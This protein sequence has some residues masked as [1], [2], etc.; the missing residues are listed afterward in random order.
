MCAR[1]HADQALMQP[2]G[3]PTD[4]YTLYQNSVHGVAILQKQDLRAP[5]CSTCHGKHGAAPP[6]FSQVAS[7]CGQ[8]HA[9][10]QEYY[11]KGAH[12]TGM[13][14]QDAPGCVTCHGQ[15]DV[16]LP[17]IDLFQGTERRHCGTCH[18]PGSPTAGQVD[19]IYQALK[20]ADG[21]YAQ[22]EAAIAQAS[23]QHLIVAQQQEMLQKANTPL[24]ESRALQHTVNVAD[25]Q[26]KTKES[27]DLS[28]QAQASA[29]AALKDIGT[30]RVGMV[31]ALAV[32]LAVI[33]ALVL[34]KREL[35]R[36]LEVQRARRHSSSP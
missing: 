25:V 13:T 3:F 17:T 21:A 30:R 1:C 5:T 6:G 10:T 32:I 11:Q 19:A 27:V 12:K 35:D 14:G 26:A 23:A 18:A 4:Q 29:E 8:C 2:Y 7:V 33:V 9:T 36:D 15:H 24:I 28:Q 22:A 20:G 16:A 34:I 31:I